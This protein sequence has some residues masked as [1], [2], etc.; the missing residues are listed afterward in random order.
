METYSFGVWLKQRREALRLTQ[1]ELASLTYCSVAMLKKIEADERRPSPELA[2]LLATSLQVAEADQRVF[3]AVARGERPLDAIWHLQSETALPTIALHSPDPD[4]LPKP[5]T[6]F[7]GRIDELR[8]IGRHLAKADCRL[9]TLVGP[10]GAGKT[11]LALAA[12]QTYA[13]MFP[14]GTVFVPLVAITDAGMI[15]MN[16]AQ[17]LHL[18]PAGQPI[19]QVRHFLHHRTLLLI[20]DNCEQLQGN[21]DWLSAL[22]AYAPGIKILTTSRERLHLMEEWVYL[23]PELVQSEALFIHI[24]HRVKHN[25]DEVSE[26][27]DIRRICE[28]V[29]HLPLAV[30]LAASWTPML[31]CAQIADHIAQDIAILATDV[32]NMPDRHRSIQAVFDHSW[33]LLSDAEQYALMCFSTFRGSW[34]AEEA[35]RVGHADLH[36]LR[37]LIGKSLVRIREHGRY[38]LH[39]LIRQYAA[40]KLNHSGNEAGASQRHFDVYLARAAQ[41]NDQQFRPE[42][43]AVVRQFDQEY[44]NIRTA[45]NWSLDSGQTEAAIELM[46]HLWFY[47]SRRGYYYEGSEWGLRAIRQA[48]TLET[49]LFSIALSSTS[50]LLF[51]QGRYSEAEAIAQ[52]GLKMAHRL[53]DPE[54]MIMALGTFTFTSVNIEQALT[55]LHKGIALI[56]QTGKVQEMLPLLYQGAATW[57]HGNGRYTEARE[58]YQKS[59]E[60]FRDLHVLDFL[61]DPLGRLGQLALREGRIQEAHDLTVESLQTARATGYD[62]VFSAWGLARL[63]LIQLYL[64]QTD[65]AQRSLEEALKF[66]ED[67]K[68]ARVKQETL[69]F[70]SEA[71][72]A[73][74]DITAAEAYLRG[75]LDIAKPLYYQLEATHKLEGTPDAL[76]VDLTELCMRAALISAAQ[77]H[78]ERAVTLTSIAE[79]LRVQSG[80]V[81]P[82][83]LQARLDEAMS[84]IHKLLPQYAFDAAWRAGRSMSLRQAFEF[85]LS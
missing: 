61:A 82:P 50:A 43:M 18:S 3:I 39:E 36:L 78:H 13:S 2:E 52:T 21:L 32:R 74:G 15:P 85:L 22:F 63:G 1:R 81:M 27:A 55:A 12:A 45:L 16:V 72:L 62:I 44:D 31:S 47:W 40:Q 9:L 77:G 53:E 41:L 71:A 38:E 24:A 17:R 34:R 35:L 20:L 70:L 84:T 66:F 25:F 67:D 49:P 6:P 30:E 28:L 83:P 46:Y 58:Y 7:I 4:P 5:A 54:A 19:E 68:D 76:P 29:D 14:D 80:S 37:G 26:Q 11:R 69:A 65:A 56:Q 48:G 51:V 79:M 73:R 33:N 60:L 23:V 8:E 10:G 42:G 75:S 64:G 59:I 57:F